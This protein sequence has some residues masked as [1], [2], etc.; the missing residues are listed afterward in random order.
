MCSFYCLRWK[1]NSICSIYRS[2][3]GHLSLICLS[4]HLKTKVKTKPLPNTCQYYLFYRESNRWA[5]AITNKTPCSPSM[6]LIPCQTFIHK[7]KGHIKKWK[8]KK[9][10]I[11]MIAL[12]LNCKESRS[13]DWVYWLYDDVLIMFSFWLCIYLLSLFDACVF[14]RSLPCVCVYERTCISHRSTLNVCF[15]VHCCWQPRIHQQISLLLL[16]AREKIKRKHTC[17]IPPHDVLQFHS[18]SVCMIFAE[19]E[20]TNL[21]NYYIQIFSVNNNWSV[22]ESNQKWYWNPPDERDMSVWPSQRL[23]LCLIKIKEHMQKTYHLL[24]NCELQWNLIKTT[25][26][27]FTNFWTISKKPF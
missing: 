4:F 14:G 26:L 20:K 19:N 8:K 2:Y 11:K 21:S 18:T 12:Y 17:S 6:L 25:S 9:I 1:K 24:S 27:Y 7:T 5:L 3:R 16:C 13:T 15:Y 23:D 10:T 22:S